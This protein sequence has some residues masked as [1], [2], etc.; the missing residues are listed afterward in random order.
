MLSSAMVTCSPVASSTSS[1]RGD[2]CSVMSRESFSR[3]S[4]SPLIAETTT[5]TSLPRLRQLITLSATLPMRSGLPTDVP[6]YFWTISAIKHLYP[7]PGEASPQGKK[8]K[9]LWIKLQN[10]SGLKRLHA[11]SRP[12]IQSGTDF[13]AASRFCG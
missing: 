10:G 13:S 6:P 11:D 5:T 2:G 8:R 3:R 12:E 4:V 9:R 1:S 7:L